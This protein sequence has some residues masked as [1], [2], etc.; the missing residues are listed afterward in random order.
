MEEQFNIQLAQ[1]QPITLEQ[2]GSIR[3]MNRID[4]KYVTNIN[5]LLKLLNLCK[6][7]Y[8]VQEINGV[9]ICPY[10][11]VYFD[12][13]DHKF[14]FDHQYG[15]CPRRKV[16][17]RTYVQTGMS[18]LEVKKKNN[19][20]RTKKTRIPIDSELATYSEST[21]SFL[22]EACGLAM[23]D[24]H[25][26][27]EN[28]FQRI[29]LVNKAKTERLTMDFQIRFH[30][31]ETDF[32]CD[33]GDLAVIEL[34]RDGLAYSPVKEM[35]RELRIKENGFSKY[36]IGT[37]LTNPYIKQNR[38]KKKMVKFRKCLLTA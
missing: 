33:T 24:M 31:F 37:V 14:Y 30:N 20:G 27:V 11:T 23:S 36:C 12:T 21:D 28:R 34:K 32:R 29:T 6:E 5:M 25:R 26:V 1:M 22:K 3:L 9:R 13:E 8:F 38:F 35:L 7:D 2:M 18:F 10:H 4:K 16:R 15:H 19:H 17:V